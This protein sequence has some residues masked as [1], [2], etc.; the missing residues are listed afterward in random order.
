[1]TMYRF[2]RIHM[3]RGFPDCRESR[4]QSNLSRLMYPTV[5]LVSTL[6]FQFYFS[7]E[8]FLYF[9]SHIVAQHLESLSSNLKRCCTAQSTIPHCGCL[10]RSRHHDERSRSA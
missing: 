4:V 3:G 2:G 5:Q 1:M 6:I 10:S 9:G 8:R 7:L